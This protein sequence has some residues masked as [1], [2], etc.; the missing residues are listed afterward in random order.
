MGDDKKLGATGTYPQ[1]KLTEDDEGA[2]RMAIGIV[3]N[4]VMI[5]FGTMLQWVAMSRE[6]AIEF[7]GMIIEKAKKG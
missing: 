6:E 2:V 3:D 7:A 1:G 5:D 4:K